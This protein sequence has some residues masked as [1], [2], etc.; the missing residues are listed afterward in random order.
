MDKNKNAFA[1]VTSK[2]EG[3]TTLDIVEIRKILNLEIGDMEQLIFGYLIKKYM[4]YS[5]IDKLDAD[6]G[7]Y[8]THDDFKVGLVMNLSEFRL[9][10]TLD[11]LTERGYIERE[12]KKIEGS[13]DCRT[14]NHF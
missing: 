14:V 5:N 1:S 10:N 7:F 3:R 2:I 11:K 6:G 8:H 13:Q 12:R 4:Y 9:R